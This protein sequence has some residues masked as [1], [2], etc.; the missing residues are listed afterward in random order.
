M[1]IAGTN[2]RQAFESFA[3]PQN[4]PE[5][6]MGGAREFVKA[7]R[8]ELG[9]TVNKFGRP[10]L[11]NAQMSPREHSLRLLAESLCGYEWVDRLGQ[12]Q[13]YGSEVFESGNAAIT[14]GNLPNVSAF[15]GSVSGL[16]DA[17]M[18][19][20]YEKPE[21]VIDQLVE[22]VPSRTR[23]TKLIGTGRIGDQSKH[24]NPG[25][26]HPFAQFSERYVTTPETQNDALACS[27]TFESVFYDQ[28]NDVL[29]QANRV[30]E[31]LGLRK[32]FDGMD[33]IAGVTN[34]YNYKG[35]SYNT[36]LTTGNW[37]NDHSNV[38]ADWT[39]LDL[40]RQLFS[41][42]TDQ[43]TG[44]RVTVMP[45]TLLVAPAKVET[46]H[47]ILNATEVGYESNP[48]AADNN[49]RVSANRE[50][51]RYAIVSSP[52]LDQ[53]LTDA[54]GLNLSQANADKY[55]WMLKAKGNRSAFVYVENWGVTISRAAPNDFTMLNHK[56]LLAVFADQMGSFMVREPR[57]VVRNKN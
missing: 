53:R 33:M 56:L 45:D 28:T 21:F 51:G 24:R 42:M 46:A 19:E 57:Y 7:F 25:D 43:E 16:L 4:S 52:Y 39:D 48:A 26:P 29:D 44:N 9:L 10:T 37:I 17:A 32:E 5:A 18:L 30:G 50:G 27:V 15:L 36:Y 2:I 3:H 54:D 14:P 49:R 8:G 1:P 35:T 22:T 13:A 6:R 41:R 34:P 40:A 31:E 12:S 11:E 38:L 47:Y 55:W 23:Q 20:G